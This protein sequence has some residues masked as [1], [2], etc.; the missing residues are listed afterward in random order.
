MDD[1]SFAIAFLING[2]Q[3]DPSTLTDEDALARVEAIIEMLAKGA[4]G[5]ACPDHDEPPR[6]L[7]SGPNFDSLD[8]EIMGCCQKIVDLAKKKL[9]E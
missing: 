2:T 8:M 9:A 4:S 6:F 7:F 1:Q 3:V 5:L